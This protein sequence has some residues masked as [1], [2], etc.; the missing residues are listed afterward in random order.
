MVPDGDRIAFKQGR[1]NEG[2]RVGALSMS[3]DQ[4]DGS[5][6]A[7]VDR[8]NAG[9]PRFSQLVAQRKIIYRSTTARRRVLSS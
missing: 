1:Y 8:E 4:R 2:T 5:G 3:P 9:Q 7:V 6:L